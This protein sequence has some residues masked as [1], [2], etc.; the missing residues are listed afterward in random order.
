MQ[1]PLE[2]LNVYTE[3]VEHFVSTHLVLA[4]LLLLFF[5]E[6]GV[7]II[8][9]G[10]AILAYTGYGISK[11]HSQSIFFATVIALM[12]IVAGSSI[13][14]FAARRWGQKLIASF[15]RFI[16]LKQSRI[17]KAEQMFKKYGAWTI[18]IGRHIPGMRI[19]ITL[20]AGSSGIKYRTFIAS[21][22]V[23][24]IAW[25]LLYL[26]LGNRYGQDIQKVFHRSVGV[27]VT[28]FTL[29]ILTVICLHLLGNYREKHPKK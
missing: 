5:E 26:K 1:I 22:L 2:W 25:V 19:P 11:T 17:D 8:V 21:T 14:F 27:T 6:A 29:I 18:I 9:P 24:T 28:V 16:F 23:S 12:A 13:L 15:G 3:W 4:P 7:P 10:D 20:L